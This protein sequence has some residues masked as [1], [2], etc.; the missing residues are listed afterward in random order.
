MSREGGGFAAIGTIIITA[1][2]A[3]IATVIKFITGIDT[4]VMTLTGYLLWGGFVAMIF[5]YFFGTL[6]YKNADGV[7]KGMAIFV[8]LAGGLF[9]GMMGFGMYLEPS[10]T[11]VEKSA[12][13][14]VLLVSFFSSIFFGKKYPITEV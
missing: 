13:E 5:Y 2:T 7:R 1:I 14:I 9:F 12:I 8:L 6:F 10:N 11:I 4:S 3:V